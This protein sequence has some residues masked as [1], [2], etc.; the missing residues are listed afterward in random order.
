MTSPSPPLVT[1]YHVLPSNCSQKVRLVLAE[2]GVAYDGRSVNIGPAME[3]YEPWY[4]RLNPKAVV[5][6]LVH[7]ERVVTDSARIIRY[8]DDNF[9]G[10]ALMPSDP[11]LR[12]EVEAFIDRCDRLDVRALTYGNDKAP[13]TLLH[14][15]IGMRVRRLEKHLRRNPALAFAYR[16]KIED[17]KR[18]RADIIDAARVA[19]VRRD[20]EADLNAMES[21]LRDGRLFLVGDHYS[22]AD[23]MGTIHVARIRSSCRSLL[24]GRER[25]NQWYE[26]MRARPSFAQADLI[27]R[28]EPKVMARIFAEVVAPW[29]L[30]RLAAAAMI[31]VLVVSAVLRL[32]R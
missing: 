11:T 22:L 26:R 9:E 28:L 7:G 4:V 23:V 30:P 32:S 1:L 25:V 20:A 15:A 5:P 24:H 16:A 19:E 13:K 18:W 12:T 21:M 17:V 6:T 10:P 2:K 14:R 8:V 3:N 27:D 31:T 29:A